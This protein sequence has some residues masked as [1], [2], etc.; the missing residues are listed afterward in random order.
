M[1]TANIE[2]PPA[3]HL[4]HGESVQQ[5]VIANVQPRAAAAMTVGSD[6]G[7]PR[8]GKVE[9]LRGGD[10]VDDPSSQAECRR[11]GD[12][13]YCALAIRAA[14]HRPVLMTRLP[15]VDI[16]ADPTRPPLIGQPVMN[17]R[18]ILIFLAPDR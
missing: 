4:N 2:Y 17:V 14:T 12:F 1:A 8:L 15:S 3:A 9:R 5:P 16:A 11:A 18:P 6:N 13:E 10:G 7:T